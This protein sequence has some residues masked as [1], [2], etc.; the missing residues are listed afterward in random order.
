MP[1]RR[2]SPLASAELG[3]LEKKGALDK[4]AENRIELIKAA[5]VRCI[6]K[7]GARKL[8]VEDI[9]GAAGVSRRTFY[10]FFATRREVMEA[11]LLDRLRAIA[12]GVAEVLR[13][14]SSFEESVVVGSLATANLA[15]AD[16]IYTAI[17][18]ADSTLLLE[19]RGINGQLE[20]LFMSS[21]ASVIARARE[22]GLLRPEITDDVAAE[23]IMDIHRLLII[24]ADLDDQQK[25][26]L[27]RKFVLP[28]LLRGATA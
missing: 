8:N 28:S 9:A 20:R 22:E 12:A 18:E 7:S 25:A 13:G 19:E 17:V 4:K 14:C 11:V 24:R 23:W 2:I 6:R 16:T 1:S 10:R 5:A 26:D 3:D 27:I 21:W 15:T